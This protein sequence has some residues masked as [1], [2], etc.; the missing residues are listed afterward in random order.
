MHKECGALERFIHA[1]LAKS[2]LSA[3]GPKE[4]FLLPRMSGPEF[5]EFLMKQ[6]A[7][8]LEK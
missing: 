1:A 8:A 4:Y 2:R 6:A 5:Q 7:Q 3:D